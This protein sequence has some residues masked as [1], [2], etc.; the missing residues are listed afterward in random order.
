MQIVW[1]WISKIRFYGSVTV[2]YL[3]TL[4]F[5][6]YVFNPILFSHPTTVAALSAT[7]PPAPPKPVV[8]IISGLPVRVVLP[9]LGIDLPIDQGV[10][11]AASDSWSLSG[12]HA[13]FA[14]V[15]KLANDHD[16]NTFIYGHNNKYVFGHMKLINPGYEALIYTD[17]GHIFSYAFESAHDFTPSDTSILLYKGPPELTIQTCSGNWNEWRRLYTF[18]FNRLLQ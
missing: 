3:V 4:L 15:S 12:Y 10:Y 16:G 5:A 7:K 11:N 1:K 2:I 9:S 18:K 6:L 14:Y 13:Q 8:K 17:N